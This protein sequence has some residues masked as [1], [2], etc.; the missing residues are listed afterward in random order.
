MDG[1]F[2][3]L[4]KKNPLPMWVYDAG[5]LEFLDV[6]KAAIQQ[7]GYSRKEFLSMRVPDIV[8]DPAPGHAQSKTRSRKKASPPLSGQVRHC[9]KDGSIIQVEL[10]SHALKY[11]GSDAELSIISEISEIRD[12]QPPGR[13]FLDFAG[14]M[15]AAAPLGVVTYRSTGEVI[16]VNQTAARML[17]ATRNQVR[18]Q[19]FRKLPSWRKSGM[20]AAAEEALSNRREHRI[21]TR[22]HSSFDKTIWISCQ[23]IPFQSEGESRLLLL[24]NDVTDQKQAEERQRDLLDS[25]PDAT[26]A[27]DRAGKISLVNAQTE[28]LF[29]YSRGELLGRKIEFL[30]P[31]RFRSKHRMHRSH[32]A[33]KPRI[34][35]MGAGL[36]LWGLRKDG[37]EFPVKISLS[38]LSKDEGALTIASIRD[39][40]QEKGMQD[41]LKAAEARYRGLIEQLPMITYSNDPADPNSTRYV[42]PQIARILGYTP[43]E[44]LHDPKFWQKALYPD[45]RRMILDEV[46]R[47]IQTGESFDLEYRMIKRDGQVLWVHDRATLLY[48]LDGRPLYWQGLMVDVTEQKQAEIALRQSED[49]YRDLVENSQLLICT[50]DLNGTVLSINPWACRVLG[51]SAQDVVGKKLQTFLVSE[52]RAG[53]GRY[54]ARIRKRSAASGIV[55]VRTASGDERIWEYHNTLRTDGVSE[56]IVRGT[57][58]DITERR[59]AEEA[60]R[61]S[62]EMHRSL[63]DH[64]LDGIFRTTPNGEILSANPALVRMLGYESEKDLL[65]TKV[66]NLYVLPQARGRNLKQSD[67]RGEIQNREIELRRRDGSSLV[68]LESSREVRDSKGKVIFYEGTL[69]DITERKRAE[70]ALRASESEL[71]A[72]FAAIPDVILVLDRDGRYLKVAPTNPNSLYLPPEQIFGKRM[73]EIFSQQKA[74]EFVRYIRRALRTRRPVQFEYALLVN[75]RIMW[76]SGAVAPLSK[77]TVIWVARDITSQKQAEEQTQRR[78]I[79]LEAL[80]ESGLILS[81]T[82]N[83]REIGERVIKVLSERLNWHHAA[84]RVRRG[85]S[86]DVELLAFSESNDVAGQEENGLAAARNA[87]IKIGQG[88][89]GWVMKNGKIVNSGNLQED[90]RYHKTFQDMRSG[91]YV[92]I[93]AGGQVIGCVSVESDQPDMFTKSDELFLTTLASQA[94]SA[95]E[96]ARLFGDIQARAAESTALYDAT[97]DLTSQSDLS[98][99]LEMLSGKIASLLNVPGGAVYLYDPERRDLEI[100]AA[101]QGDLPIGTRLQLGEGMAGRVA[102]SREPLIVDD[103]RVWAG[104]SSQFAPGTFSS[105]I[106]VPMLYRGNLIGVLAAYRMHG[107]RKPRLQDSK[108]T[109]EDQKLLEL[110]ASSAAGAV[111][112]AR[113]F[114]Q[115]RLRRQDAETLRQAATALSSSLD[116]QTVLNELLEGLAAVVPF[117][118][119]TV[120]IL[121]DGNLRAMSGRGLPFPEKVIGQV[122]PAVDEISQLLFT[123]KRPVILSDADADPRFTRWGA[124]RPIHGWMGVPLVMRG[125]VTGYITFDNAKEGAYTDHDADMAMAFA[126]HAA[127]AIENARLFKETRRRLAELESLT[128]VSETLTG[129]L[130]LQPLLENILNA[131]CKAIPAAE[132]GSILLREVEH[133]HLH[134]RAQ[135]G[136]ENP[137]LMQLPF[138]DSKGYSG[139][140]FHEKRPILVRD[141]LAEYDVPFD[142]R[143]EEVNSIRSAIVVP[144]IVKGEAIGAISLDNSTRVSAFDE[145]DLR[146]LVVFASSAAVVIENARLFEQTQRRAE[147]FQ[148]LYEVTRDLSDQ[149]DL[150]RLLKL[151]VERAGVLFNASVS[152]IYLYDQAQNDMYLAVNKG[153]NLSLGVRL[154]MGEGVAGRVA[155]TRQPMII[156]DYQVWDGRSHKYDGTLFRSVLDVPMIYGGDLIGVLTVTEQGDSERKFTEEDAHLLSLF[157]SQAASAV[158][159]ARLF[160][161]VVKRASQFEALYQTAADLAS[162]MDLETLLSTIIHRARELSNAAG[163][164]LYLFDRERGDLEL[165]ANDDPDVEVGLHL[166]LGEGAAGRAARTK[167]P[168]LIDDYRSWDGRAPVFDA[169]PYTSVMLVP[170]LYN[171]E[172]IGVLDI[173]NRADKPQGILNRSFDEQDANL[174]SLFANA[175]AGAV[176]GARLLDQT[177]R[178]LDELDAL[179]QVSSALRSAI[180]HEDMAP[181]ILPHLLRLLK[182]DG[183]LFV[184]INPDTQEIVDEL[185]LGTLKPLN[186]L[187]VPPGQGVIAHVIRSRKAYVTSDLRADTRVFSSELFPDV[188]SAVIIP[189]V[190]QDHA[191]GAIWVTR[192]QKDNV[193]PPP[194]SQ[195][196]IHLLTAIGD[197]AANAIQRASLHEQT[198]HYA[199][200]LVT[201]NAVG[202]ALSETLDLPAIYDKVARSALDLLPETESV[203]V[204]LFDSQTNL[205]T[206]AYGLQAGEVLETSVLSPVQ[207]GAV[208]SDP[209][210]QVILTGK[211][212]IVPDASQPTN[213]D[214]VASNPDMFKARDTASDLYVPLKAEGRVIGLLQLRSRLQN[215]YRVGDTGLLELAANTAAVAIQNTRLF[216]QLRRRVDQLSALHTVDTAIS[217]TTDLRVSLQAVLENIVRQLKVDAADVLLLNPST[218]IMQHIANIG[219]HT[220]EVTGTAQSM[221]RGMAGMAALER[222]VVQIPDLTAETV[223]SLR[224]NLVASERFVSYAAVPLIAKGEVKGV[225]EVFHRAPMTLDHERMSFLE[226]LASQAALAIDNALLFEDLEKAN[227]ELTMA[228]DATIEGWSQ[229]L[230]LRDQETQGHSARVLDLTLRLTDALG[231]SDKEMQEIRR[232]VLLHD[233]GKMGIPDSILHKPGPLT[234]EE[235]DIMRK[236]PEYAYDM[237][238]PISYLRNSLDIPYCHHEHWDGSGYPRGLRGETIPLSARVFSIVDV[239]DAL[240]SD[241][242]YRGA[243]SK[244][245]TIEYIREQSGKQFD[246]H[247]VDVFLEL[248]QK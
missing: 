90:S 215:R 95:L 136:Y 79:E 239:Y 40:T 81:Q 222:R 127:I 208:E 144:L 123:Q 45:D 138:D 42:S 170:M 58:Y 245:K 68:A 159:S 80:Y 63:F 146:L 97:Q 214:S 101:T 135:V 158:Y 163:V 188:R 28:V 76:F 43:E 93:W 105:V 195:S 75:D 246:P 60:L 23:F 224:S 193:M 56:P 203:Y 173:N 30:I 243:W 233:I 82:L 14:S 220:S 108:F 94:A 87:I 185:A 10:N 62:E 49:R 157:A 145:G 229:A 103:Y 227:M 230:E 132:K 141:S 121:E 113:L 167:E 50:H 225:L 231:F 106:E 59:A 47:T 217:S 2:K 39:V 48:D 248:I 142:Q 100:V 51:F 189:L 153:L 199:E 207:L 187:V 29:G 152:G 15:I 83:P 96:N 41:A 128:A 169:I 25:M 116:P 165:V 234:E 244:E 238:S 18:A 77:D 176:Y 71:R 16:S 91:L 24:I 218:L 160:E 149:R 155:Q 147:E 78:V 236:H 52:T 192:D 237:I 241:R 134:V 161:Q 38:P 98:N 88:M 240:T 4:F 13:G 112:S 213:P 104:R 154:A 151:I 9:R 206:T 35:S 19:N 61:E 12:A 44:W 57:A 196:E 70:Q 162:E 210:S 37:S 99:L 125:E 119:A 223:G 107:H 181:V 74:D 115:E 129:T 31:K 120:F 212:L 178:R 221:G 183:T 133:D 33:E 232:G 65:S 137:E 228:Y 184:N 168:L 156:D 202:R 171:G 22:F 64:V 69:T 148:A 177:R 53:F 198:T 114:E 17:G 197:M 172:L 72:L 89:A 235:W 102:E 150:N 131:A 36:E 190:A 182:A 26:I 85:D 1:Q 242:P 46:Q 55:R 191:L 109:E 226:M 86:Q 6:N 118:S 73:H 209:Q 8:A 21:E 204:L 143:L 166:A 205:I 216:S 140:A 219:F 84:I 20:L 124:G 110:F 111:Y 194:F 174:I 122:Y 3:L 164:G 7:Y 200:Q 5:T 211:S 54:L 179:S 67:S 117:D 32:Y 92:P 180:R 175:A 201:I 11:R 66:Q 34:R 126:S 186:G 247:I 130:E 27:I 139:R